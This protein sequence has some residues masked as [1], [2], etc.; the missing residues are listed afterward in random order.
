MAEKHQVLSVPHKHAA[1]HGD[2]SQ[3]VKELRL[4]EADSIHLG[5]RRLFA[6]LGFGMKEFMLALWSDDD[7]ASIGA[8]A[9]PT[10]ATGGRFR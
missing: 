5:L 4:R 1:R 9:K 2:A 10:S 6:C 8:W 3:R 7:F